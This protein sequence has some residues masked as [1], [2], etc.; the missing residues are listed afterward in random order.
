[1]DWLTATI[2]PL[3][4]ASTAYV[5]LLW[6]IRLVMLVVVPFRRS[7]AAAKAWLMLIF[8]QPL[9]GLGLYIVFGRAIQPRWLQ[10]R[11]Q[12]W[13]DM[14]S[15]I[16]SNII[17]IT[18]KKGL[19]L[20]HELP[21]QATYLQRHFPLPPSS[22]NAVEL[23]NEYDAFTT[24]LIE[25]INKAEHHVHL[26]FYIFKKDATGRRVARALAEAAARGVTCR[27]LIDAIGSWP[28]NIRRRLR[29]AGVQVHSALPLSRIGFLTRADLRNHRKIA[30][31]DGAVAYTGSQNLCNPERR[32]GKNG[33]ETA[34]KELMV[35]LQGPTVL[36]LQAIFS[37]DWFLES[38][39]V[40]DD[41]VYYPVPKRARNP[42]I[43]Q[44]MPSGPDY[45][46]VRVD[47]LLI[48]L[49]HNARSRVAVTTPYF[50]PSEALLHALKSACKRGVEVHIITSART[51]S[52]L[53]LLA[54]RSYYAELMK[55]GVQLH[56]Y[57]SS[58]L[59]A[60][61]TTIDG[62][63]TLIGSSNID[64]R[65]FELNGEINLMLYSDDIT[66]KTQKIEAG[67]IRHAEKL[68]LPTWHS[69]S[70]PVKLLENL[71]RLLSPLL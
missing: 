61:H 27:V 51:D 15:T 30:V 11:R 55:A 37:A 67:Y 7:P 2:I 16:V 65:S 42:V 63:A 52:K 20:R 54:Q 10:R 62:I 49:I 40:L 23:I 26:L 66:E 13:E 59:H 71:A 28:R 44:I 57:Q 3:L 56:I 36:A 19:T 46:G 53:V 8:F 60:K 33:K 31:I 58:F 70:M 64:M 4:T 5:V 24:R 35:R 9:A 68:E 45:P 18:K 34:Q 39:E 69:R 12:K 21:L 38:E 1:M 6:G 50:I 14:F 22:G 47:D 17:A 43:A 25:D 32:A 29:K 48:S 41:T